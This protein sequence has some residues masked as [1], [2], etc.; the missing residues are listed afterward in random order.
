MAQSM[1]LKGKDG[2]SDRQRRFIEEYLIDCNP[3]NAARRC[4]YKNPY[5]DAQRL[6]RNRH[7]R[8]GITRMI[9][10]RSMRT[11]IDADQVLTFLVQQVTADIADILNDDG[12]VKPV[13]QWP[14][15]WRQGLVRGV[16][17]TTDEEGNTVIQQVQ[18]ADRTKL[19]ELLGKHVD[20]QAFREQLKVEDDTDVIRRLQA[21][22]QRL[23]IARG[24][25]Q[26][27]GQQEPQAEAAADGAT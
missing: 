3:T 16:K 14:Y 5:A 25:A 27:Q 17:T 13:S 15:V 7:V 8:A 26:E 23:A 1:R 4:G 6:M 24:E 10:A 18:L 19:L 21:G 22:R 11:L 9:K 2:L 12:T 20:V